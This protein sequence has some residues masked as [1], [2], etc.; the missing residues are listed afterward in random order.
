MTVLVVAL[1]PALTPE[2]E[3]L[4]QGQDIIWFMNNVA[5]LNSLIKADSSQKT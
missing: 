1:I 3:G 4:L 5:A 2:L